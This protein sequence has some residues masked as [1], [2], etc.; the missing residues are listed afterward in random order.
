MHE[1]NIVLPIFPLPIFLLPE[2]ITRL[3]IFEQRYLKMIKIASQ[4]QGFVI[5]LNEEGTDNTPIKWGSWVDIIN[6]DQGKDGVLEVDVKC[7]SLVDILTIEKDTDN[8][9]FAEV[10]ELSHWS[11]CDSLGSVNASD[12]HLTS[13]L[14]D[15]FNNDNWLSTV[16]DTN[17]KNS[18]NWVVARWLEILPISL[19]VKSQFVET[20][21]FEEANQFVRSII[22]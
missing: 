19:K 22:D 20:H 15:V 18:T 1:V 8:L 5:W 17:Q 16:Y 12:T 9:H 4:G 6:F 21:S 13:P 3:R 11:Q 10:S 2:G 7:K 14:N